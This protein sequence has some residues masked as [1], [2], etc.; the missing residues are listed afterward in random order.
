LKTY[1]TSPHQEPRR[2]VKKRIKLHI[3][4]PPA[5]PKPRN[6]R[7]QQNHLPDLRTMPPGGH[8]SDNR[9]NSQKIYSKR[10]IGRI[11]H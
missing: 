11:P 1:Q 5:A 8:A 7:L 2:A 6:R 3:F 4:S 10:R 9:S